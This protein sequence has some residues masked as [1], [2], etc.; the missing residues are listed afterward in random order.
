MNK[1]FKVKTKNGLAVVTSELAKNHS[2]VKTVKAL[3][4]ATLAG[5]GISSQAL[6]V[7][8]NQLEDN[9]NWQIGLSADGQTVATNGAGRQILNDVQ[10]TEKVL[11]SSKDNSLGI[12]LTDTD[13]GPSS[14]DGVT[15]LDFKISKAIRDQINNAEAESKKHSTVVAGSNVNVQEGAN[16]AGGKE[17]TVGLNKD[18]N[19]GVDG[20]LTVNTTK[21]NSN[22]KITGVTDGEVSATSKEA[23]N[24][25]QL[26]A[27]EQ[28]IK[29]P[30]TA[31]TTSKN[32]ELIETANADGGKNYEINLKKDV[33][34]G[35]DGS[36]TV[37]KTKINPDGQI[38]GVK[39]GKVA[40]NSKDAVNGGQLHAV[41][42][43]IKAPNTVSTTSKNVELLETANADGG[44]NYEVNLKKDV[45]LGADGSLTVNKTKINPNGK[46][47]GVTDGEVSATS[48]EAVNGSQLHAIEQKIKPQT[49]VSTSDLNFNIVE[50]VNADGG[51]NYDFALN[52]KVTIGKDSPVELDGTK[53]TVKAGDIVINDGGKITGVNPAELT[54]TSKDAVNG[55]QLH[56]TNQKVQAVQ[57]QVNMGWNLGV[58]AV[59]GGEAVGTVSNVQMGD[60]VTVQAGK[61]IVVTQKGSKVK[62]ATSERP[63]FKSVKVGKV[64]VDENKGIDAGNTNINNVAPAEISA[65]SKQAVNGS[66]LH[67]TN[68][69]VG[70]LEKKVNQLGNRIDGGLAQANAMSGLIQA[71]NTGKSLVSAS[72]GAYRGKQAV[73]VG[74]SGMSDNGKIIYKLGV[75]A[76]TADKV[77]FGGNASIGYQF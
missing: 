19:L 31:S 59:D 39:D 6:A 58:E 20:S 75:G 57:D 50:G 8:V 52:N 40:A 22:G 33:D 65:T 27:V 67:A 53:G 42:Q 70:N 60:T 37:N 24:G 49:T 26:H 71:T 17:Y 69:R 11:F 3:T 9:V 5:L 34:L 10:P 18:V 14:R 73:A 74:W 64:S 30:T 2:V 28:K 25:S 1:I 45:D 15:V 32:V 54:E 66:Q 35:A 36:L 4:V 56:A 46:I 29:A 21:I 77:N 43:K 55:S 62:V 47:S 41:E 68:Q 48:K 7:S 12:N 38:T 13:S 61:N 72:V 16:A 51:K 63:E 44:K 76:N 23:V